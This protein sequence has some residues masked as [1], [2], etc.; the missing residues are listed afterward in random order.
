MTDF[1]QPVSAHP[2][3]RLLQNVDVLLT[4]SDGFSSVIL[5]LAGC[6]GRSKVH[7]GSE[8]RLLLKI[9]GV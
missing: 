3:R 5:A 1:L 4:V 2:K 6:G 9:A 7:R 8:P